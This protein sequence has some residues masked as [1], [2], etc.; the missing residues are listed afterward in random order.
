[1][2]LRI[3]QF[4]HQEILVGSQYSFNIRITG[5]DD[6]LSSIEYVRVDG[7]PDNFYYNWNSDTN[8]IQIRGTPEKLVFDQEMIVYVENQVY[9]QTYSIVPVVPTFDQNITETVIKDVP[10]SLPVAVSNSYTAIKVEGPYIG[11]KYRNNPNGFDL[12]GTIPE[13]ANFTKDSFV[14]DVEVSNQSGLINGTITLNIIE[15][16]NVNFYMLDGDGSVNNTQVKVYPAIGASSSNVLHTIT[17]TKEF[18]LPNIPGSTANYVAIASDGTNLYLL[19]SKPQSDIISRPADLDDQ[20]VV[21]S[22]ATQNGQTA[23]IIR[24]FAIT[25]HSNYQYHD[26]DDIFYYNGKLYILTS[27]VTNTLY[28]SHFV[29]YTIDG[30]DIQRSINLQSRGGGIALTQGYLTAVLFNRNSPNQGNRFTIYPPSWATG[31]PLIAD[32]GQTYTTT[33]VIRSDFNINTND[34]SMTSIN[35]TAYILSS[36]LR[37]K[38]SVVEIPTPVNRASRRNEITLSP[39]L[40]APRG[41]AHL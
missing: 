39:S 35:N 12:Y 19:H 22:P 18:N 15:L 32:S 28:T 13:I 36:T 10:F 27:Y 25:R 4:S 2:A 41:I 33:G 6:E 3:R 26:L 5:D 8:R 17:K 34:V 7:L 9:S 1:M 16:S 38:I 37:D 23:G 29:L 40:T 30:S 14:F 31:R 21:V 11:L 24:R 20:I